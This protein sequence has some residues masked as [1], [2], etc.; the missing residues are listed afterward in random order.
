[1]QR[2]GLCTPLHCATEP[3][4]RAVAGCITQLAMRLDPYRHLGVNGLSQQ[5]LRSLPKKARQ[6][7]L[8]TRGWQNDSI[9]DSFMHGGVPLGP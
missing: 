6:H 7:V 1:M 2:L 5:P 9:S 8:G 3:V 4:A